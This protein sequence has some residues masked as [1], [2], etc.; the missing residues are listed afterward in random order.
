MI[1]VIKLKKLDVKELFRGFDKNKT[2]SVDFF[3]FKSMLKQLMPGL[4]DDNFRKMWDK[5]DRN[6]SGDIS[7]T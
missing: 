1:E 2:G 4:T 3:E 6:K 5:F 7:L